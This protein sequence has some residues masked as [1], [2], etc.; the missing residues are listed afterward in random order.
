MA[1]IIFLAVP[2]LVA[3]AA[4][5]TTPAPAPPA[6]RTSAYV[7]Q[8]GTDTIAVDQYTRLGDRLE[9]TLVTRAPR[10]VVTRYVVTLNPDGSPALVES[11]ARL[12]DGGLVPGA[13]RNVTVTYTRDSALAR[14]QRDT[15]V[16]VGVGVRG[17][18]PY[19][20]YG[21][22]FFQLLLDALRATRADTMAGFVLPL[23]GRT[24][25][26]VKVR[27]LGADRYGFELFG[28]TY[29]VRTD[30]RGTIQ[31]V[32][33]TGTTQQFLITRRAG[34]D[35][36]GVAAGW[37]ERERRAQAMGALSPRDTARGVIAGAEITVDYGRPATR[38]R[39]IFTERGILNDTL[40]RTGANA[41]T[42]LWTN[43]PVTIGGASVPAGKY[44]LWTHARAGR[45]HLIINRQTGQWG[46]VYDP[47]QDLAR[48]PLAVSSIP[49]RVERFTILVTPSGAAAGALRLRWDTTE[50][51]VPITVP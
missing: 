19:I 31:M 42:Q 9:G 30:D 41:A 47:R 1:R 3:L 7:V 38:G 10:T 49:E 46:T 4:C 40:W 25:F 24:A 11:S 22:A 43:A 14:V 23:G 37:A 17:A 15:A 45:Y 39:E 51:S 27:H 8:L 34:I 20:N 26:P 44:S 12:P 28:S 32:D 5:R 29:A 50:L 35:L 2:T 13:P 33:G 6:A 21:T 48:V 18:F 16:M 36:S